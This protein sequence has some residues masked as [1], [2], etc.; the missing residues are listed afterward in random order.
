MTRL[1]IWRHG[2]TA[3]NAEERIQG[4]S[5]IDLDE[6]GVAQ[7]AEAA[8]H[9]ATFDP[10]LLIS[11]DLR[12]AANTAS[13]LAAVTGLDV[14]YDARLRERDY[15]SWQGLSVQEIETRHPADFARWR[16]GSPLTDLG[17]EPVEDVA[18]RAT[19]AMREAADRA[20]GACAV[21]VTHGHAGKAGLIGML[22]WPPSI[23]YALGGLENCHYAELRHTSTRGWQLR[24]YNVGPC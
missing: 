6:A 8:K 20:G 2:Q 13:A 21:L 12:R 15:G 7:A 5:D 9:L 11:S 24:A 17:F 1:L 19:A 4:Q 14:S 18:R 22:G 10:V 23:G 3:W 16:A